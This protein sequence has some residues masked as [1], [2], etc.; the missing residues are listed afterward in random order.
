MPCDEIRSKN[1]DRVF[2]KI[3]A[4][5]IP[6]GFGDRGTESMIN[7]LKYIR[8]KN[9]PCLC[10]CLGMQLMAIEYARNVLGLS[11]A[12]ST[13]FARDCQHQIYQMMD[14]NLR[15]GDQECFIQKGSV[16][17]A[18]YK[19]N[20]MQQRHRHRYG[21]INPGYIKLFNE[22]GL[23]ISATSKY[24]NVTVAEISELPKN[25]CYSG[26][27]FHPEFHSRPKDTDPIFTYLIKKGIEYK[28]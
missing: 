23:R 13:E 3:N 1:Y 24:G 25:K 7:I 8:E 17:E 21:M 20:S 18:I 22:K 5:V 16:A 11:D 14:G 10:I 15:L 4:V 28:K 19:T 9:I 26:C 2:K 6:G 27:Q 12:N